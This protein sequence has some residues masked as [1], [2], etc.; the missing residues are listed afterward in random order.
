MTRLR[1]ADVPRGKRNPHPLGTKSPKIY[2]AARATVKPAER[3]VGRTEKPSTLTILS[4]K[5][6]GYAQGKRMTSEGAPSQ[7]FALTPC[8]TGS[9]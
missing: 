2:Q 7:E 4:G 1:A 6:A 5:E 8:A 9:A 3:R